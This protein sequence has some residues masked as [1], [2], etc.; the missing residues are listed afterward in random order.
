MA[1]DD[2]I[3]PAPVRFPPE[4]VPLPRDTSLAQRRADGIREIEDKLYTESLNVIANALKADEIDGD[5]TEPPAE[6]VE[7]MGAKAAKKA[8]RTAR[9][10]RLPASVRPGHIDLAQKLVAGIAKA[11]EGRAVSDRPALQV[12]V[13]VGEAQRAYAEVIDVEVTGK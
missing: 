9:D 13:I 4:K 6:W 5:E 8:H 10:I 7:E 12:N 1:N 3:I 11:R 2:Y